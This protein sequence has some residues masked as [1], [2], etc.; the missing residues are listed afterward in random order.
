[1]AAAIQDVSLGVVGQGVWLDGGGGELE[2]DDNKEKAARSKHSLNSGIHLA[3]PKAILSFLEDVGLIK[4]V[5]EFFRPFLF[6]SIWT[7]PLGDH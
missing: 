7:R 2:K 4:E 3:K 5:S 1:M 6:P